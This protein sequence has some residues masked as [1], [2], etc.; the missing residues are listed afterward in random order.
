MVHA[1]S[2][3]VHFTTGATVMDSMLWINWQVISYWDLSFLNL[4]ILPTQFIYFLYKDL[5]ELKLNIV[6]YCNRD[7]GNTCISKY[8]NTSHEIICAEIVFQNFTI[9]CAQ[10][11]SYSPTPLVAPAPVK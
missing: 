7:K 6:R 5:G 3:S 11:T 4:S 2:V 10:V 1:G 8:T 9:E